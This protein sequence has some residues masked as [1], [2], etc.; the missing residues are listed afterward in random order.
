MSEEDSINA[1]LQAFLLSQEA[2]EPAL[3]Q[4]TKRKYE[5]HH[6]S[7]L[8]PGT[9]FRVPLNLNEIFVSTFNQVMASSSY[10]PI[11]ETG[12]ESPGLSEANSSPVS[13]RSR[14]ESVEEFN[15]NGN[16]GLAFPQ[17]VPPFPMSMMPNNMK[18]LCLVNVLQKLGVLNPLFESMPLPEMPADQVI[19]DFIKNRSLECIIHIQT[20]VVAQK[21]YATERRFLR[22]APTVRLINDPGWDHFRKLVT[23]ANT[24]YTSKLIDKPLHIPQGSIIV[25]SSIAANLKGQ[26]HTIDGLPDVD[27]DLIK[28][29]SF[30]F[31]SCYCPQKLDRKIFELSV[32]LNTACGLILGRFHS[33]PIHIISKPSRKRTVLKRNEPTGSFIKSG[34]KIALFARLRNQN[35]MARCVNAYEDLFTGMSID[36]DLLRI[37]IVENPE[38]P[39]DEMVY[40][41]NYLHYNAVVKLVSCKTGYSLPLVKIIKESQSEETGYAPELVSQLQKVIFQFVNDPKKYLCFNG[42]SFPALSSRDQIDKYTLNKPCIYQIVSASESVYKFYYSN[43]LSTMPIS[44]C[45]RIKKIEGT[46]DNDHFRIFI[47]GSNFSPFLHVWL[48]AKKIDKS[49]VITTESM[50][51]L[52][53]TEQYEWLHSTTT[54]DKSIYFVREDG[55]IYPTDLSFPFNG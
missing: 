19:V 18:F 15:G 20:V 51:I 54:E 6:Q 34:S 29:N 42:D 25:D 26:L 24:E 8:I 52:L 11:C 3:N 13:K 4:G 48:G 16:M 55:V 22:P 49:Y 2:P 45:P 47:I 1:D 17:N 5:D 41:N 30:C 21:S 31:R 36:W 39:G 14:T 27:F 37:Y 33:E 43:G 40:S 7:H 46:R 23:A 35:G 28:T 9:S 10:V 44:P 53:T 50:V 38:A 12:V 32:K